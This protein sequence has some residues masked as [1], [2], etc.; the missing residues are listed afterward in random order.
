MN[1]THLRE[2]I[3]RSQRAAS[4]QLRDSRGRADT[5][6]AAAASLRT[7]GGT[8]PT[9]AAKLVPNPGAKVQFGVAKAVLLTSWVT[10]PSTLPK[11]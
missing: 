9:S 3:P 5:S 10:T 6:G 11:R 2:A 4:R 8:V 7:A 1:A